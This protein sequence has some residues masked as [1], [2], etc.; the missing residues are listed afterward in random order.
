M[1]RRGASHV[2]PVWTRHLLAEGDVTVCGLQP[3]LLHRAEEND[4]RLNHDQVR[5]CR[6]CQQ[7]AS[8]QQP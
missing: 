8:R 5:D 2:H 1:R 6:R 3:A 7:I 4:P